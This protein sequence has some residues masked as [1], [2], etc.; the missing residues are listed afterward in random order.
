[1]FFIFNKFV[2]CSYASVTDFN[3]ST[4]NVNLLLIIF[5]LFILSFLLLNINLYTITSNFYN[6]VSYVKELNKIYFIRYIYSF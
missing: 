3:L 4:V 2:F 5:D 6:C 1:M